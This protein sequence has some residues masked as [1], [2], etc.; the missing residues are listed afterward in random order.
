MCCQTIITQCCSQDYVTWRGL[1]VVFCWCSYKP[2]YMSSSSKYNCWH[3]FCWSS[4]K[5]NYMSLSSKYNCWHI[6]CWS[7]YIVICLSLF[8]VVIHHCYFA[9]VPTCWIH[10]V[11]INSCIHLTKS[12]D[13]ILCDNILCDNI[14]TIT[15]RDN[16]NSCI[17][18]TKTHCCI[19]LK[20]LHV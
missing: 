18:L 2:N 19:L 20:F 1:V 16:I 14:N 13:N 15:T 10:R 11:Y 12:R 3:I 7:S 8:I 17:H 9:D 5:P 6:F 4:Y